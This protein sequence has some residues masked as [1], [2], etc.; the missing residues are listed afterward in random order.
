MSYYCPNQKRTYELRPCMLSECKIPAHKQY[1][2]MVA[3]L[4]NLPARYNQSRLER[5]KR[6]K[7]HKRNRF[8]RLNHQSLMTAFYKVGSQMVVEGR[9]KGDSLSVAAAFPTSYEERGV[10]RNM[11]LLI[12]CERL[13]GHERLFAYLT[14]LPEL[15][16]VA[17]K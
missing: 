2:G 3:G 5:R 13:Q 1:V 8:D 6:G 15:V 11:F 12:L 9:Y 7:K 10:S 14:S 17:K 4:L 16:S